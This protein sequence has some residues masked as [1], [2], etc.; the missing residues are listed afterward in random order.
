MPRGFEVLESRIHTTHGLRCIEPPGQDGYNCLLLA[1][2]D[3]LRLLFATADIG[4][5]EL[6]TLVREFLIEWQTLVLV[7]DWRQR[8]SNCCPDELI[9]LRDGP[10]YHEFLSIADTVGNHVVPLAIC[11]VLS[12]RARTRITAQVLA[13]PPLWK[14]LV[15][16][17]HAAQCP[18]PNEAVHAAG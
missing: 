16:A 3:Q 7:G 11:G 5:V 2:I 6:R 10:D 17:R 4:T 8:S 1:A 12:K 15:Y 14:S 9:T 13:C 18:P